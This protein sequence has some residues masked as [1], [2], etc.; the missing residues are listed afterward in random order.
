MRGG[1]YPGRKTMSD[2][3]HL[4]IQRLIDAG[5]TVEITGRDPSIPEPQSAG[6]EEPRDV[7]PKGLSFRSAARQ[8]D[9]IGEV[10][11]NFR[12]QQAP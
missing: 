1:S 7:S 5:F 10:T 8:A 6:S 12:T 11:V 9:D 2:E 4:A 3:I